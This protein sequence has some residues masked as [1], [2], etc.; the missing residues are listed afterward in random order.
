MVRPLSLEFNKN[1]CDT[2]R[3][4]A[5]LQVLLYHGLE[6]FDLHHDNGFFDVLSLFP[7][8]PIFFLTSVFLISSSFDRSP[9]LI[10]YIKNRVLRI[11]PGLWGCFI[12]SLITII[13]FY[14]F[15]APVLDILLWCLAQISFLQVYNPEFL[16]GYGVGVLNGSLWT[17]PIELQFY[18]ILSLILIFLNRFSW[19]RIC[20]VLVMI[21]LIAVNLA[22]TLDLFSMNVM[23]HKFVGVTV[24]PFLMLLLGSLTLS[25]A[26][27]KPFFIQ[28]YI[29]GH[30]ISCGMYIYHMVIINTFVQVKG[31]LGFNE[32]FLMIAFTLIMSLLSWRYIENPCL[33]FKKEV[34]NKK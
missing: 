16:R 23:I 11:Y 24:A 26:Y 31:V 17:I 20:L 18:F 12:L 21:F 4:V 1:N 6:Y 33:K 30:D 22:H 13:T 7:G 32:L 9:R 25:S 28:R 2:I 34:S 27:A 29:A 19:S 5:A 14:E 15:T 8:V 3:L 10:T